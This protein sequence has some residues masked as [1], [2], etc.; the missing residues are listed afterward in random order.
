MIHKAKNHLRV[1]KAYKFA[2]YI[3]SNRKMVSRFNIK[4][5][6]PYDGVGM[7]AIGL[8]LVVQVDIL[9]TFINLKH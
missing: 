5:S 6:L 2:F 3:R 9:E 4:R 8:G 7:R 1:F